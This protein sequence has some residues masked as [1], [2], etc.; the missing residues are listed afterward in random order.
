MDERDNIFGRLWLHPASPLPPS[1]GRDATGW[2]TAAAWV[3]HTVPP[4]V[5]DRH[6]KYLIAPDIPLD[7]REGEGVGSVLALEGVEVFACV[8]I[9]AG[10]RRHCAPMSAWN[11]GVA[12]HH[13][14]AP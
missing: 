11:L 5:I 2:A 7:L 6:A 3:M 12:A 14:P 13:P 4:H 9:V 1:C 10:L 8:E